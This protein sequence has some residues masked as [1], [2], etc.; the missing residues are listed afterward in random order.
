MCAGQTG[1]NQADVADYISPVVDYNKQVL[2]LEYSTHPLYEF[3]L[4]SLVFYI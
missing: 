4:N 3:V 2:Y 1:S